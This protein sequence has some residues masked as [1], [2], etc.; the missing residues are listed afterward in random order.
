MAETTLVLSKHSNIIGIKEASGDLDQCRKII[1]GMD[2]NFF[3]TS[4]EDLLTTD[5]IEMGRYW[6]NLCARERIPY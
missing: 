6:C 4:G 1:N 3:L 2:S 5:L